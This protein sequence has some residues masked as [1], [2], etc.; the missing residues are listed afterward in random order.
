MRHTVPA[1]AVGVG[2][3][4]ES[5]QQ[6]EMAVLTVQEVEAQAGTEQCREQQEA[7]QAV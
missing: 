6:Q 1:A 4:S 3:A 7:E 2:V 5:L